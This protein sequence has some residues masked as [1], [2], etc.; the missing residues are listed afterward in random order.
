M[1][2][3]ED[4]LFYGLSTNQVTVLELCPVSGAKM[5]DR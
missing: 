4:G 5:L 2:L 3:V 1:E